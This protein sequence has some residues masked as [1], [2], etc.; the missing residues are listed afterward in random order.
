MKPGKLF[1]RQTIPF[2]VGYILISI[3]VIVLIFYRLITQYRDLK[4]RGFKE[5]ENISS[6]K[7]QSILNFINIEKF[8]L[9]QLVNSEFFRDKI[10]QAFNQKINIKEF[11]DFLNDVRFIK[12][13]EDILFI[14]PEGK[15]IFSFKV[16]PY[17]IDSI[18][19]NEFNRQDESKVFIDVLN[20]SSGIIYVYQTPLYDDI[21]NSK[22][23]IGYIRFQY[24]A[25]NTI[26]PQLEHLEPFSSREVL[27]IKKVGSQLLY[28]SYLRK[29]PIQPLM[30]S[31]T[32][33]ENSCWNQISDNKPI[34]NFEEL[35]YAG[36]PVL[37]VIQ[38]IPGT[39]WFLLNKTK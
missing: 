28:L 30:L 11:Y 13:L 34:C 17:N 5:L 38:S 16:S 37:A 3:V 20:E 36:V 9:Q 2:I 19:L 10:F 24:D 31:E 26:L 8:K 1:N 4:E 32:I 12:E 18:T 35:D 7:T 15:I 29:V 23:L 27:L 6:T 14:D 21:D 39:N 25:K 33:A 22:K